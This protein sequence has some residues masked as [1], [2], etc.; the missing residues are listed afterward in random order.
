MNKAEARIYYRPLRAYKYQTT[1]DHT[2]R[3][4]GINPEADID[5]GFIRLT[6]GG[7]LTVRKGYAWDGATGAVDTKT[8][9][10]GS[11]PHDALC[12]LINAGLLEP[13]RRERA[14]AFFQEINAACGMEPA[15]R[16]WT[17]L[18]VRKLAWLPVGEKRMADAYP[19]E[20][21]P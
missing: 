17:W 9:L 10:P 13:F 21:A 6:R 18:G 11:L 15:R 14:D 7:K 2:W 4:I 5:T 19:E 16:W 8:I 3:N 20:T 1:R 12:Q